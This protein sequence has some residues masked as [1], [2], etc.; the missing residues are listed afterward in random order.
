M[1]QESKHAM[2]TCLILTLL[3]AGGIAAGIYFKKPLII[4]LL[5]LPT[6]IYEL[7]RTEG[8][9]TKIFSFSILGLLI[10]EAVLIIGKIN[11]NAAKFMDKSNISAAK[12][13]GKKGLLIDHYKLPFGDLK[14]LSATAIAVLALM[15]F[16]R[17][18]GRYTIWLAGILFISS[19]AIVYTLAPEF[20]QQMF[21]QI[22]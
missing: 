14:I 5:L 12:Y 2:I 3:A 21:Q 6:A 13:I 20:F 9:F 16:R 1:A 8:I 22:N 10:T 7:Y 17:T 18:G 15:L 19:L 11:I 4:V